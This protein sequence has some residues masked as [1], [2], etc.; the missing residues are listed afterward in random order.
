M[1]L[2]KQFRGLTLEI[3]CALCVLSL[4]SILRAA[5]AVTLALCLVPPFARAQSKLEFVPFRGTVKGA[6][7][8]PDAGPAPHVGILVMFKVQPI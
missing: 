5:T 6:L 3:A 2:A 8:K 4:R 1:N 7:Y